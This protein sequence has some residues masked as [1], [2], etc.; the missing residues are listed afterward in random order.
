MDD[1]QERFWNI[2]NALSLYRLLI[3]PLL[4]FWIWSGHEQLTAVFIAISL[5]TDWLDGI[6]ARSFNMQTRIG[7]KLD[8]WADTGTFICA[9]YAIGRFKWDL[10][11]PHVT[12]FWIFVCFWLLSYIIV[13]IRFKGIIGLHTYLFKTTGYLQGIFIMVLFLFGFYPLLFYVSMVV[14]TLACIEEIIIFYV[15]TEPRS[16]V[17]GLYWILKTRKP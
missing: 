5:F 3:F 6:I 13:F 14:G 17:K 8:S 7:A 10:I 16:N 2:P 15:L 12:A 4:L 1:R 9:F 11:Q